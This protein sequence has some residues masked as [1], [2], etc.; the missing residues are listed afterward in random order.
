MR[1][2]PAALIG[3]KNDSFTE[4]W[5]G[6]KLTTTEYLWTYVEQ[7][8]S[9]PILQ[10]SVGLVSLL[11]K[12]VYKWQQLDESRELPTISPYIYTGWVDYLTTMV[13]M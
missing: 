11:R 5:L 12:Q 13:P 7:S 9:P 1:W 4:T 8:E 2:L 10:C 3:D 6:P